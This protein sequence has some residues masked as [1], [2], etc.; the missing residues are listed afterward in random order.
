MK[1]EIIHRSAS[2]IIVRIGILMFLIDTVYALSI[3]VFVKLAPSPDYYLAFILF[4]WALHTFKYVILTFLMF[5]AL[6]QWLGTAYSLDGDKL[7]VKTGVYGVREKVFELDQLKNIKIHQD[8]IARRFNYGN[9]TLELSSSGF[10]DSVEM[11]DI[12]DPRK[13]EKSLSEHL[14]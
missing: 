7:T 4:L 10:R 12:H 1:N 2:A 6:L 9:I 8:W 3:L 14:V 11:R 13:Y 5:R